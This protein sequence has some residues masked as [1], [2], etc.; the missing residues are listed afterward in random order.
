MSMNCLRHCCV[1]ASVI[2]IRFSWHH[3]ISRT[4]AP[5]SSRTLVRTFDAMNKRHIRRQNHLFGLRLL[6]Q[7]RD[8]RLQI[9]RLNVG[10][11][12][13]LEARTQTIFNLRQFLRRTVRRNHDLPHAFMQ[14]IECVE[15]LFL[16][17]LFL[18]DELDVVDQQHVH[19]AEAIAEAR[20]AIV[21]QRGDHLVGE[22][23][24]RDIADV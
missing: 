15:E 8:L 22:L 13:P 20:H 7:N 18:R 5:S 24:C 3:A 16:R 14:R 21:A 19:G 17:A 1:A 23:L 10:D 9:R 2:S 6:L 12:S 4:S 11:Q